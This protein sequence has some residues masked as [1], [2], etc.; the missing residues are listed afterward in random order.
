MSELDPA[1]EPEIVD[2]PV[3]P[4]PQPD[5]A[6]KVDPAPEP[7]PAPEGEKKDDAPADEFK[8]SDDWRERMAGGDETLLRQLKRYSSPATFAKGFKERD[9]MIRS[10][11]LK[12]D[13]PDASDEKALAEWR[14][15]QGIPDDPSGYK[16]GDAIV[17]RLTDEDKPVLATFTEFAHKKGLP[18]NA[19]EVAAEWYVSQMDAIA[20]KRTQID[21]EARETAE[22]FLRKEWAPGEFKA[23]MNLA[24]RFIE[25]IPGVGSSWAEFRGPDGR[26]L[27]D[28]PEFVMAMADKARDHYGDAVFSSSDSEAKHTAR[29]DEIERIMRTDINAYRADPKLAQEYE[30]ILDRELKRKK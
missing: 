5:P 23:N 10:G 27:G 16:L 18:N 26:R 13:M 29:K 6:P 20:E 25:D 21:N 11:K 14:K 8:W 7:A 24:K 15:E 28:I 3:D 17:G 1:P 12:R 2:P 19:V 22:D 4:A 30:A 9:D